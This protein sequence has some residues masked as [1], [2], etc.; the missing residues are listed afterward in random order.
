MIGLSSW[1]RFFYVQDE[2][3]VTGAR[4]VGI[5]RQCL[6]RGHDGAFSAFIG[7]ISLSKN[8]TIDIEAGRLDAVKPSRR[9]L[10][11]GQAILEKL[12]RSRVL[13]Y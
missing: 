9:Y 4:A 8:E 6:W 13:V 2:R 11:R 5:T 7:L 10:V 1:L 3:Y 12:K